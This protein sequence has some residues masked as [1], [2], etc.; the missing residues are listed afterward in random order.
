MIHGIG[1]IAHSPA[2]AAQ[3]AMAFSKSISAAAPVAV[4]HITNGIKTFIFTSFTYQSPP[5]TT[6]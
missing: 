6:G 1:C 4:L 2:F 3:N 5:L